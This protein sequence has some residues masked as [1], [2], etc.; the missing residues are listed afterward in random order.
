ML[1]LIAH[2]ALQ[3]PQPLH[4]P[5]QTL[6]GPNFE[7]LVERTAVRCPGSQVRYAH[8]ATLLDV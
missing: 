3:A 7:A 4:A 5:L 1:L 2:L 8:P 6:A